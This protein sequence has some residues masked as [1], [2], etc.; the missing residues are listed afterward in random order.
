M[1]V[2]YKGKVYTVEYKNFLGTRCYGLKSRF[3]NGSVFPAAKT[4]CKIV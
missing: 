4:D 2:I 3:A 1:Q